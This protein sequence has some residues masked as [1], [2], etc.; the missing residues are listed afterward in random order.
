MALHYLPLATTVMNGLDDK[1][2][3]TEAKIERCR[4]RYCIRISDLVLFECSAWGE[5]GGAVFSFPIQNVGWSV[6]LLVS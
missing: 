6:G 1:D 3:T 2:G 4:E 5:Y